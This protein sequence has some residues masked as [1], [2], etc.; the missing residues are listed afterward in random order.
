MAQESSIA[1][2]LKEVGSKKTKRQVLTDIM[3]AWKQSGDQRINGLNFVKV[4]YN[5]GKI[6]QSAND[7]VGDELHKRNAKLAENGNMA[8]LLAVPLLP[9][10][11]SPHRPK[12]ASMHV[13][14]T[15]TTC[16]RRD[17]HSVFRND[18]C[19]TICAIIAFT[20]SLH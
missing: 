18:V 7:M 16:L 15:T 20:R 11:H 2:I 5:C 13:H 17:C 9:A 10:M 3:V 4:N 12:T 19:V 1:G 6:I 8:V 14:P